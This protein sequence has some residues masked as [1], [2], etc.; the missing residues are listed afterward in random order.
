MKSKYE[1]IDETVEYYENHPRA[2]SSTGRCQY[3]TAD[4]EVCAVGRCVENP[5][6]LE[7][8]FAIVESIPN[9]DN[10]LREDYRGHDMEFWSDLQQLHDNDN[11][12]DHRRLSNI[13]IRYVEGL[14]DKYSREE[15]QKPK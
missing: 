1:I 14:W 4:G 15:V 13:G 5:V 9:L 8:E 10:E 12:W 7:Q 2:I 11:Y 3:V 6:F